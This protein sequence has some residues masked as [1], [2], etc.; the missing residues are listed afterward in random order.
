MEF[1][2][3]GALAFD[4]L[5]NK[6]K[7]IDEAWD[8]A[9]KFHFDYSELTNAETRIKLVVPFMKWSKSVLPVLV[10]SFG[11]NPKA[12]GRLQQLKGEMELTSEEE[13]LVPDYFGE[14]LGI[15]LPFKFQGSRVYALPDLP[16][17][18]L[19]RYLKEPTSPMRTV[20]EGMIPFVKLPVEIW[21]GKRV[22][23]DIPFS[24]RY[25]QVP[26]SYGMIPGLM[27]ILESLGKAK[28]NKAGEYKMRDRDIYIMDQFTPLFGRLRRL[29]PNEE[30]K[31]RRLL[32]TWISTMTG[33]GLRV[34][35]PQEKRNQWYRLQRQMAKDIEDMAD[36]E[37]REV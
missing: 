29:F 35:D 16:F 27:P 1:V 12:W 8:L 31:Q 34:N 37:S 28:K 9:R 5:A 19:A 13:G 26:A 7:S 22:F 20:A 32:S 11:K 2:L 18:D 3:R 6:G 4:A 24:G 25:Q 30:S 10:E 17:K 15:R 23:A 33:T 36:I 14:S 21:S